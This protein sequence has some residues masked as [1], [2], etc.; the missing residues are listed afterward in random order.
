MITSSLRL[1]LHPQKIVRK[2]FSVTHV[3][4]SI[5][6]LKCIEKFM[7]LGIAML[8]T[9]CFFTISPD[10]DNVEHIYLESPD[11]TLSYKFNSC[12]ICFRVT[13]K[14][15]SLIISLVILKNL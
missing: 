13:S 14:P 6:C 4:V 2:F 5:T 10:D 15:V 7:K 8:I 1:L 11:P 3:F 12:I 9:T